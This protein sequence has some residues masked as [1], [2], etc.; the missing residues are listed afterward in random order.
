M[1]IH[2][3]DGVEGAFAWSNRVATLSL[4]RQDPGFFP[5]T[6]SG[7]LENVGFGKGKYHTINVPLRPGKIEEE[8]VS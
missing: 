6:G 7:G 8:L 5:G 2:H 1:D 4:H 3:G